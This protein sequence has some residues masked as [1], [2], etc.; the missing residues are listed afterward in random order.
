MSLFT[1]SCVAM[2]TPFTEN[3]VNFDAL[4]KAIDFQINQGTDALLACGTTGEPT[5]MTQQEK[6]DV[7]RFTVEKA[8]GRLPVLAGVGGNCTAE[9]IRASVEAEELGADGLLAVNPY[10]NKTNAKG[11]IAHFRSV[12]D[13]VSIP[14]IIYN[15]PSRTSYN[16]SPQAM[17]ELSKIKNVQAI[18]EASGDIAQVLEMFRLCGDIIDI[19]SGNDDMVVPLL[20]AGGKGVISVV[21]NIAPADTHEM[22]S[23]FLNGNRE[24]ALSLQLKL[25]PL[26]HALFC[27]VNPIPV[28][29][30]MNLMG[31]DMGPLRL[32]LTDMEDANLTI[33]KQRMKEYGL[34]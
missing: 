20:A 24:E 34:L 18:K 22:V 26:I 29:T 4:G 15:V 21:A 31:F 5:T 10:Y 7:I 17:L 28:K 25:L 27:E 1:G 23:T 11:L 9:V 13:A 30:A 12:S 14:I 2:V 16:I 6:R 32:P 19:Y 33:L 8:G 3:G